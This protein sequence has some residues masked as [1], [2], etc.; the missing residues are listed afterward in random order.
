MVVVV[1]A[2]DRVLH[3]PIAATIVERADRDPRRC[4]GERGGL[5]ADPGARPGPDRGRRMGALVSLLGGR[6]R[7]RRVTSNATRIR[8]DEAGEISRTRVRARLLW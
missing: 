1:T 3:G 5:P 2:R 8:L 6:Q 4:G 7:T